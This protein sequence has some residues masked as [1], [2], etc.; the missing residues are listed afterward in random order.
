MKNI[1]RS[2]VLVFAA[3]AMPLFAATVH[4]GEHD[5]ER[6]H[7]R[8]AERQADYPSRPI[9]KWETDEIVRKGMENI[10]QAIMTKQ[11]GIQRNSL[12]AEGYQQ[13]A[14]V[15]NRNVDDIIKNCKLT[16]AVDAALHVV[17]L[18]DL[19]R[20]SELMRTSPKLAAQR[21]AAIGILQSLRLY[22]E[23][24]QHPNWNVEALKSS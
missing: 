19:T 10:R 20:S 8:A 7:L 2:R 15:I 3:L 21:A 1:F 9:Q 5:R 14:E 6:D 4:A 18:T 11:D 23:Y 17:V 16:Q 12:G 22:G 24:F 13:L